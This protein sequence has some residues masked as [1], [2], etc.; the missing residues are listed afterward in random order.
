MSRPSWRDGV[1]IRSRSYPPADAAR[2]PEPAP[3]AD[4]EV[5][6]EPGDLVVLYTD[7][8]TDAVDADGDRFGAG[9]LAVAVARAR[10][11][12]AGALAEILAAVDRFPSAS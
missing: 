6:F 11:A 8:V 4:Q 10:G 9:A 5:P 2:P 3:T 7:G 12:A 1:G